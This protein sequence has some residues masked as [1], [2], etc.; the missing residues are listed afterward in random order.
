MSTSARISPTAFA[1]RYAVAIA[2]VIMI[3]VLSFASDAFLTVRNIANILNQNTPL[4]IMAAAMTFVIIGGGFDLSV[5]AI[6]G[7]ASVV[8]ASLALAVDPVIGLIVAPLVG[9][10]LGTF[11]GVVVTQLRVHS[12]LATLATGLVFGGLAIL[13]SDGN[14]IPVRIEAFT[15]LGRQQYFG[16]NVAVVVLLLF[17]VA[18]AFVLGRTGLGRRVYAV[19]GN[20][21]AAQ[22]SGIRVD[23]VRI[24]TFAISGLAAGLASAIT[25]SR[26]SMGQATAGQGMELQAIAAVILGGTSIYGG[27]GA[28]WRS[29]AGVML[30][31]LINNGFNILNADPFYKDLAT[32]VVI[33]LAVGVSVAGKRS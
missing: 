30:L 14:L 20:E 2:L 13:I 5:G 12:F 33:L 8:C 29:V 9:L 7:V 3:I 6:F 19:G 10:L 21:Q 27:E 16:I 17:S 15:W 25:V 28:V 1:Q 23:R 26:I 31:A 11:N 24:A 18:L 32:G 22:L 4:A